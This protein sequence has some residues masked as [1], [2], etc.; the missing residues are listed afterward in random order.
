MIG[1]IACGENPRNVSAGSF[2]VGARLNGDIAAIHRQLAFKYTGIGL[3]AD[4]DKYTHQRQFFGAVVRS[5]AE[6]YASYT[7]V[8]TQYF[9]KGL[10]PV[11]FDFAL[12]YA[13]KNAIL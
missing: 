9:I 7:G 6:A 3:V 10:I 11:C 5:R 2:T 12:S 1:D 4:C 13:G 8:V